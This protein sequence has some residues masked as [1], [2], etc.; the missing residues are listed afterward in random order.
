MRVWD[1]HKSKVRYLAFRPDGRT[2]ASA[3]EKT[4]GVRLWSPAT[5]EKAG[6]L[7]GRWGFVSGVAFSPDGKLI[8]TATMNYRVVIWDAEACRPLSAPEE[9]QTRYSPAFSPDGGC[10]AATGWHGVVVWNAPALAHPDTLGPYSGEVWK[11]DATFEFDGR[12]QVVDKFD[13]L[14]F[15]PDGARVAANG[16]FRAVVWDRAT[17]KVERV[18]RHADTDALTALAFAPDGERLAIGYGKTAEVHRLDKKER[19]VVLSGHT[20]FVRAVGFTPDGRT[21]MTA[22]S[23]G[24]VRFWDAATGAQLRVFDWGIGRVYSAAFSPDGLTCAA[25]G[26]NGQIVVWDVDA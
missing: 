22:G 20:L 26:E 21:A 15:S 19:S 9:G 3:A 16:C 13:S 2:L 6:E 24:T 4:A 23:D 8:A 14:A 11:P 1:A 25:G 12:D 10:V 17:G 18:I 7:R 5:G